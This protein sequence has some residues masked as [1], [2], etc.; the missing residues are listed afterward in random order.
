MA[1]RRTFRR[2]FRRNKR[3]GAKRYTGKRYTGKRYTGTKRRRIMPSIR[4]IKVHHFCDK[5]Q[6]AFL[7]QQVLPT[8]NWSTTRLSVNSFGSN[9]GGDVLVAYKPR[10]SDSNLFTSL[11]NIYQYVRINKVTLKLTPYFGQLTTQAANNNASA[12]GIAWNTQFN[13]QSYPADGGGNPIGSVNNSYSNFLDDPNTKTSSWA[14][15]G[16]SRT[17]TFRP[18][19]LEPVI[20][21]QSALPTILSTYKYKMMPKLTPAQAQNIEIFAC[22]FCFQQPQVS[23]TFQVQTSFYFTMYQPY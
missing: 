10:L 2:T 3:T 5:N 6:Q 14:A 15:W 12:V 7:Y 13:Y 21:S 4:G 1:F 19:I 18:R 23:D 16:K 11:I 20:A 22:Q 9:S 17:M 8:A